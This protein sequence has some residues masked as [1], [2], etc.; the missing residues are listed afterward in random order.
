M[1]RS[2]TRLS[3][4]LGLA[5]CAALD[6]GVAAGQNVQDGRVAQGDS[7]LAARDTA[8]ARRVY[9]EVL[10][11][12]P[13]RSRALYQL[14]RIAR[15]GSTEQIQLLQRYAELE[16]GDAWGHLAYG[17][18]LLRGG[19]P[20]SALHAYERGLALAPDDEDLI[21]GARRAR[22]MIRPRVEPLLGA[23]H[24]SDGNQVLT[25]GAAVLIVGPGDIDFGV[26]AARIE[27]HG[28]GI[29]AATSSLRLGL[30][31]PARAGLRISGDV[32]LVRFGAAGAGANSAVGS[33]LLR[34]SSGQLTG[35]EIRAARTVITATPELVANEAVVDELRVRATLPLVASLGVRGMARLGRIASAV[36]APNQRVGAGAGLVAAITP[37]LELSANAQRLG[38]ARTTSAG[39]FAPARADVLELAAYV[40]HYPGDLTLALDAG[41]GAQRVERHGGEL[42]GWKP[43]L[44]LWGSVATSPYARTQL[45]LELEA[46]RSQLEAPAGGDGDW[47]YAQIRTFVRYRL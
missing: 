40:E 17:D 16:P 29:G 34:A 37:L 13:D 21:G 28:A 9:E 2:T 1:R 22:T 14:G 12:D 10:R 18:A 32:G 25:G 27:S 31:S 41:A 35:A 23:A 20:R 15:R 45:G 11:A 8:Q 24:D 7:L 26:R 39:Y 44:R 19:R 47:H 42:D 4:A 30:A 43:A 33:L 38:Y 36:E 6:A 46:E 3:L 5:L